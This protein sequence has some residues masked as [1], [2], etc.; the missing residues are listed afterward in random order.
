MQA[1]VDVRGA[2]KRVVEIN[3]NFFDAS[4]EQRGGIRQVNEAVGRMDQVVRENVAVVQ[5]AA[6]AA[7]SLK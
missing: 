2:V 7:A 5:R 4:E 6:E 1:M 3:D